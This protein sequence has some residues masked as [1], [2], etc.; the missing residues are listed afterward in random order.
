M[1]Y[2]YDD[3]VRTYDGEWGTTYD[4]NLDRVTIVP[5]DAATAAI[6]LSTST[7]EAEVTDVDL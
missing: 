1:G 6:V 2:T 5:D 7:P 3:P 4:A